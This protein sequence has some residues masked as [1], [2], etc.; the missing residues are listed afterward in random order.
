M[1]S[2]RKY[3]K[4][5]LKKSKSANTISNLEAPRSD[6]EVAVDY[7]SQSLFFQEAMNACYPCITGPKCTNGTVFLDRFGSPEKTS[8]SVARIIDKLVE[9]GHLGEN[10][11]IK[12]K[13]HVGQMPLE[14]CLEE[15]S[16]ACKV[17]VLDEA[18][19][20]DYIRERG[21]TVMVARKW[22][23][24]PESTAPAESQERDVV[25]RFNING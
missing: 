23:C 16:V 5:A 3:L 24:Q 22:S 10:T 2:P 13:K 4:I 1:S 18:K 15:I 6:V 21:V 8:E 17:K 7:F 12:L 25:L 9:L 19:L 11:A 14:L 20:T